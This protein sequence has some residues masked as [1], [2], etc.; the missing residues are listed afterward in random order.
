MLAKIDTAARHGHPIGLGVI[1]SDRLVIVDLD[2]KDYQGGAIE[3]EADYRR[4]VAAHPELA[5]TRTERTPSGGI[6][7]YAE[8]AD[9]MASWSRRSGGRRCRFTTTPGGP[10]C[11]EV[12]S[13]TRISV[14]APTAGSLGAYRLLEGTED[15][16][17]TLVKVPNLGAIGI[18]PHE[19]PATPQ[20]PIERPVERPVEPCNGE[21]QPPHL[22]DLLRGHA[23]G[24]L[25]GGRPYGEDRSGN[26]TGFLKELYGLRNWLAAEGL[27]YAGSVDTLIAEA[28]QALDIEDK[29]DRVIATIDANACTWGSDPKAS[30]GRYD[31]VMRGGWPAG[32]DADGF[33]AQGGS[34]QQEGQGRGDRQERQRQKSDPERLTRQQVAERLRDAHRDGV[35]DVE[36][37]LLISELSENCDLHPLEIDKLSEAAR[38]ELVLEQQQ[39]REQ[40]RL[41]QERDRQELAAGITLSWLLPQRLADALATTTQHLP[42]DDR[43][44]AV[45]WLAD[46]AGLTKVGTT[47]NGNP[48]SGYTVP[49]NLFVAIVGD[50]GKM[51]SPLGKAVV[52]TPTEP[53]RLDLAREH[54]RAME[55]WQA[56]CQGVKPADRPPPPTAARIR[57]NNYTGESLT[58]ML[59]ELEARGLAL[60]VYREE[61]AGLFGSLN[62]YRKGDDEEQLLELFDGGGTTSLRVKAGDRIF[63]RSHVSIYGSIQPAVLSRLVSG[64]DSN[65]KWARFLFCP[66]PN[67]T[68]ALP[69]TVSPEEEQA[70]RQAEATLQEIAKSVFTLPPAEYRLTPDAL[71]WFSR[72]HLQKQ[73]DGQAAELGPQKALHG[74]GAGKVLRVAGLLHVAERV[75]AEPPLAE[76]HAINLDT[77]K[78]AITLVDTLDLW[79][80]GF[81]AEAAAEAAGGI[82]CFM[83]KIHNLSADNRRSWI[84][85]RNVSR[86]LSGAQRKHLNR[87]T[88]MSAVCRL[89][90]DNHG[91]CRPAPRNGSEYR[92]TS[93][94]I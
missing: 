35:A 1:P 6:H 64:D 90:A 78:K 59:Q 71:A 11:G 39:E 28:A 12:L 84:G 24:V 93:G 47:V 27:P 77:L 86:Q 2:A 69:E 51:K 63:N 17:H 13:G 25:K 80:S 30:R 70:Q 43:V 65:G 94:S 56:D 50:T 79:A 9:G 89:A 22:R 67:I 44:V 91:E 20:Q 15:Y 82:G 76:P 14:T 29:L 16:A 7:I 75:C 61:L 38:Q 73:K 3:L 68:R 26:M 72:F 55:R 54:S 23:A 32:D 53:I 58:A 45:A 74:K 10:H 8:V 41:R 81:H 66:L 85:W 33:T 92:A 49:T 21:Q 4:L 46:M 19:K 57:V 36:L 62:A 52:V 48:A 60:L 37:R 87:E 40:D 34:Q 83:R 42:Y 18:T 5:C 88:F 31:K